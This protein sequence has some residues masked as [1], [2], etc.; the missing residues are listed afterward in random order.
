M[1][2]LYP[3]PLVP[4]D[5]VFL[6][7]TLTFSPSDSELTVAVT[8]QDDTVVEEE[9]EFFVVIAAAPGER[10]VMIPRNNTV[11]VSI[12][13]NDSMRWGGREEGREGWRGEGEGGR[14][15]R[16]EGRKGRREGGGGGR[17]EERERGKGS[18]KFLLYTALAIGFDSA[19]YTVRESQGNVS[20]Q[21]VKVGENERP[22]SVLFSTLNGT[23][24]GMFAYTFLSICLGRWPVSYLPPVLG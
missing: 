7:R 20:V 11:V 23:A 3:L 22:V 15:G 13:D 10:G 18:L 6:R 5:F 2:T 21:V 8:V 14:M 19:S 17:K 1:Y 16:E 9:E 12:T 24:T 4:G